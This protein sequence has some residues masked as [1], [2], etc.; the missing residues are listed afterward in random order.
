MKDQRQ[1]NRP[2]PLAITCCFAAIGIATIAAFALVLSYRGA[3]VAPALFVS[4]SPCVAVAVALLPSA[5]LVL[6][7]AM[8]VGFLHGFRR[9]V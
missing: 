9:S 6:S 7:R 3:A 2:P 1:N 5:S 4:A 8:R